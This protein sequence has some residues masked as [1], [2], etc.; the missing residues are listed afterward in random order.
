MNENR[1]VSCGAIIPEGRKTCRKCVDEYMTQQ[2]QRLFT[3]VATKKDGTQDTV[4]II[5]RLS[6]KR[7]AEFG[8][9]NMKYLY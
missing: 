6:P 4:T 9:R 8:A 7:K 5:D 3:A 2:A 1:C